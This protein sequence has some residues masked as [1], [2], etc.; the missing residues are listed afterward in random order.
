MIKEI[1]TFNTELL[2]VKTGSVH[3]LPKAEFDWLLVALDE[4]M[5]EFI[6]AYNK[7]SIVDCVDSLLDLTYFAIGGLVRHGLTAEQIE[8]CFNAVHLAN[9]SKKMGQKASRP[10]DGSVAD[11]IKPDGWIAP[12]KVIKDILFSN[13]LELDL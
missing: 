8:K 1:Y 13:Q 4:E 2:G 7:Q 9:M 3:Q 6:E 5:D 10:T 11:A 12:E